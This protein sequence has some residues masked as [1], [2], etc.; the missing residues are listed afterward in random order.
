VRNWSS[1]PY[2]AGVFLVGP[3]K[4]NKAWRLQFKTKSEPLVRKNRKNPSSSNFY[5]FQRQDGVA[6]KRMKGK[7]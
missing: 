7:K 3:S 4:I 5:N 6:E 1:S 2:V